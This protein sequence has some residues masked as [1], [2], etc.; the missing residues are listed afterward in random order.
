MR[1]WSTSDGAAHHIVDPATGDS[2][3]EVWR[4][5]SVAAGSCVDANVASTAAIVRGESA[6][7]WLGALGLPSRL[8]GPEG[9]VVRV[10]GWPEED[11]R[12]SLPRGERPERL[13]VYNAGGGHGRAAAA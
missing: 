13:L 2:A 7:D 6:P 1:R 9:R 12:V 5:V 8:V 4:T 3:A 11:A 10:G